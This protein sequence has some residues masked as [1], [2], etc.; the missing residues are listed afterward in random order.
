MWTDLTHTTMY[1][2][3]VSVSSVLQVTM[4]ATLG[5]Y[6]ITNKIIYSIFRGLNRFPS[7]DL[8][9]FNRFERHLE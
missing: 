3:M 9:T 2:N 1:S 5:R 6:N 4:P 7:L 8:P